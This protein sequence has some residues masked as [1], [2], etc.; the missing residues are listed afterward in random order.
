[1]GIIK[2]IFTKIYATSQIKKWQ[3]AYD[4]Y[5]E[6]PAG[7]EGH[8]KAFIASKHINYWSKVRRANQW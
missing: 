1:M 8:R 3:A 2:K 7:T 4:V 6:Y 5:A